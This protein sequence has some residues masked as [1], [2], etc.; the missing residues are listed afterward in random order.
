M[1]WPS[2]TN[3][4]GLGASQISSLLPDLDTPALLDSSGAQEDG[5]DAH[6]ATPA[7]CTGTPP[8]LGAGCGRRRCSLGDTPS[9]TGYWSP[10]GRA[11]GEPP[12]SSG[13]T[14][15]VRKPTHKGHTPCGFNTNL[16]RPSPQVP[17][18]SGRPASRRKFARLAQR[19]RR[20]RRSP[21]SRW[22]NGRWTQ[23]V[24]ALAAAVRHHFD[25]GGPAR[26]RRLRAT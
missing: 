18:G 14:G 5:G 13:R 25:R 9:T 23:G 3:T 8:A 19:W 21:S 22:R 17:T 10:Y 7:T 20:R 24:P 16:D 12:Q 15:R 6:R 11:C 4:S 2:A 1:R 26:P